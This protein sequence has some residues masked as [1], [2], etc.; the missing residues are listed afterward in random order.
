MIIFAYRRV[1]ELE[2]LMGSI[3]HE[4]KANVEQS[5][6]ELHAKTTEASTLKLE[7]ERLKVNIFLFLCLH[8]QFNILIK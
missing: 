2:N 8:L 3:E 7:N 1:G 4:S 6:S 5:M